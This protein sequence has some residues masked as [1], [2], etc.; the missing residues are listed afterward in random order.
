VREIIN[1]GDVDAFA[2]FVR[3]CAGRCGQLLNLVSLARDCGITHSTAKRWLSTLETS[4]IVFL[5]RPHYRNF[6]KRLIKTPKLYFID[7]GLLCYL[8]RIRSAQDLM[9]HNA[10]GPI[11]ENFVIAEILKNFLNRGQEPDIYF[12]RDSQGHEI[13][14]LLDLG[15][16]L[17]PVEIK[18]GET[19][20]EDF[21]KGLAYWRSLSGQEQAPGALVYGGNRSY[22]R[23][24]FAVYAWQ[25]WG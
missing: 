25:D 3:L 17:I 9:I 24:G 8:L 5:L 15:S 16:E 19:V 1:I 6:N 13:D 7:T 21:F 23:R 4:F 18:S 22:Q 14:L 10:R 12:W 2:R 11:F 20:A